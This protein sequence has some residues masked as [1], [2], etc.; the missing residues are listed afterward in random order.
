LFLDGTPNM[1]ELFPLR[2][3]GNVK[4]IMENDLALEHDA[5]ARYNAH[6]RLCVEVGDHGTR[7]LL[8]TFL[9]N[10]EEHVD[11]LEAQLHQI[12]EVGYE[13]YVSQQIRKPE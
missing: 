13:R 9:E 3:G 2:I 12:G 8:E 7:D 11:F 6:I 1:S 4:Q 5:V 10:E